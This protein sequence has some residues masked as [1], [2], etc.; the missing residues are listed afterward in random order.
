MNRQDNKELKSLLSS[1]SPI[2]FYYWVSLLNFFDDHKEELNLKELKKVVDKCEECRLYLN[3]E[4]TD[5]IERSDTSPNVYKYL[6]QKIKDNNKN[7]EA[8]N[9]DY[10]ETHLLNVV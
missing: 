3:H 4:N 5:P 2:D 10:L 8:W 1:D 7:K 6:A 9:Q